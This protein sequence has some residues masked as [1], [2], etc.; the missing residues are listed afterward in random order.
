MI[1]W[2][3]IWVQ[4]LDPLDGY[5]VEILEPI[6]KHG[7]CQVDCTWFLT[8]DHCIAWSKRVGALHYELI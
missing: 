5:F 3:R 1:R 7:D 6:G 2:A 4:A 8:I